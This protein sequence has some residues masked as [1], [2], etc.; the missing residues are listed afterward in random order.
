MNRRSGRALT[1]ALGIACLIAS[2]VSFVAAF[3]GGGRRTPDLA[4]GP[5]PS[6]TLL[7][8]AT[9]AASPVPASTAHA[10]AIAAPASTAA[11]NRVMPSSSGVRGPARFV[12]STP[13]TNTARA[14]AP[15]GARAEPPA[16]PARSPSSSPSAQPTIH[17]AA[18][19]AADATPIETQV[20]GAA[21]DACLRALTYITTTADDRLS[22]LA[23]YN[24]ARAGLAVNVHCREPRRTVNEG[25]LLAMLAP[26]EY[27]L[28]RGDWKRDLDR[29]DQML[30]ACAHTSEF[31][32][33]EIA[34]DCAKQRRYNDAIRRIILSGAGR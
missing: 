2:A 29:S 9:P 20:G 28:G 22:R 17:A 1:L 21:N 23:V 12:G 14:R 11:A 24:A 33:T 6:V 8:T 19:P 7:A 30:D 25:Y 10:H 3:V 4:A 13:A 18:V 32:G 27:S 16:R 5:R 15:A 31:A 34:S 26:A